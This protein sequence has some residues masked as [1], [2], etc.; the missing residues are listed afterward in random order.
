M[1]YETTFGDDLQPGE[2]KRH[3]GDGDEYNGTWETYTK[4]S[5]TGEA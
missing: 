2:K 3:R 5:V 4:T 1:L